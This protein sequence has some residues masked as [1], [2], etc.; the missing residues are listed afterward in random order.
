VLEDG[1]RLQSDAVVV[2]VG[3]APA[4]EWLV[5][6][7]VAA[8]GVRTDAAARTAIPDVFAAGDVA[9]AYDP[10]TGAHARTE[11]WDAAS[12]QG[13]A[14]AFAMLGEEPPARPLPSFWSDQHG[15]RIQYIGDATGADEISIDG[16]PAARAFSALFSAGGRPVAAFTV[17]RSRELIELRRRIEDA[18]LQINPNAKENDR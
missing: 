5:G 7:G 15:V 17:G 3:V 1:R 12:R 6:S 4:A 10:R 9:R 8:D 18:Q 14:A 13:A 11:H 2:G 16:D